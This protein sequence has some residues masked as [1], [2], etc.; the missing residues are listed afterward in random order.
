M[1]FALRSLP[2]LA[3]VTLA[4]TACES[5]FGPGTDRP[6][7]ELKSLPR[8]LSVG[9]QELITASNEFALSLLREMVRHDPKP[10]VFISP[11]SAS[12]ALGM[13]MNGARGETLDG[14]RTALGF[15]GLDLQQINES[16]RSLIDLLL[17]LDRG[18]DVSVAN[19]VWARSGFP[20]HDSFFQTTRT[21]FGAEVATLDFATPAAPATINAWVHRSTKGKIPTIVPDVLPPD[22][23]MYLINAI[24]FKGAWRDRFDPS[25]TADASFTLDDGS[26]AT[27]KMMNREGDIGLR[28]DH[29]AGVHIGE[30]PYGRGAYV[31]T[32]ILPELGN[33]VDAVIEQLTPERWAAWTRDLVPSRG[34]VG[35]P[36]F[37]IEYE[38]IMNEPLIALGMRSAF[39]DPGT[40]FT[41]MSPLGRDLY[42]TEVKQKTFVDVNEE[43]TEAA[44]ATSVGVGVTS[45]PPGIRLDRPFLVA[46]RERLSGTILFLGRIGDPRSS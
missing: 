28:W 35:L 19:S 38:T 39:G 36:R 44:A 2:L 13:A 24:Y 6:Q 29:Q 42:I 33:T 23:V 27:V 43:G 7:P 32:L 8:A 41:G 3:A 11:L 4:T 37:R 31:M 34:T 40:D 22:V 10:N 45:L 5:L 30:L 15:E 46:I 14:M 9:E 21:Y 17:G 25:R 18:I 16:Y 26:Q 20:F 1:H 12:M